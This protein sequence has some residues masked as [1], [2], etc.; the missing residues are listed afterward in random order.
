MELAV[1]RW[2]AM[3]EIVTIKPAF[4]GNQNAI[5]LA[6]N[7]YYCPYLSVMLYSIV[8][9]ISKNHF[10]DIIILNR[11]ISNDNKN[12]LLSIVGGNEKVSLRFYNVSELIRGVNL[13][14]G[15]KEE[16]SVDAYLRLLIP[17]VLSDDYIKALYLDSDMLALTDVYPLFE[18]NISEYLLSS[19][20]D[21][22]GIAC[23]YDP[24]NN[25]LK[26][27]R[28]KILKL[29]YPDNYFISGMLVL[30]LPAFRKRWS[31][32]FLLEFASSRNWKQHDQDV[33]NV[34]CN[35]GE[36]KIIDASW[37]V[38]KPYKLKNLPLKL[39]E[40]LIESFRNPKIIHFGGGD[41]PWWNTLS[42]WMDI[43]WDTAVRTP[44][45]K[46]IVY[47]ILTVSPCDAK[48]AVLEKFRNGEVGF[49]YIVKYF[50]AWLRYKIKQ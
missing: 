6:A 7:D 39:R 5:V 42:P 8:E 10:Y 41:K 36:V 30:N 33:L 1:R 2:V 15:G 26:Y 3:R 49:I 17:D 45:Y 11:D 22:Q 27:Y 23:Y 21:L 35:E 37:D 46:E 13:Y 28:D 19:T 24:L 12:K 9:N 43:F 29:K 50:K 34:L 20:R 25:E 32:D 40:E 18:E 16:F 4:P 14:T 44:Y 31:S 48:E 47:R 38:L